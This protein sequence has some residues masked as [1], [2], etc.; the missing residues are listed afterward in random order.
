MIAAAIRNGC[1]LSEETNSAALPTRLVS[2]V[3]R[4]AD[5]GLG[6]AQRIERLPE[7]NAR[8]EIEGQR[9]G[10]KLVLMRDDEGRQALLQLG[11]GA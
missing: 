5:G 8:R 3:S 7:R 4:Q 6:A 10:R 11:E 2:I 9:D 1:V